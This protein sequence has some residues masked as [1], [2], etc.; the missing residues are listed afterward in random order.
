MDRDTGRGLGVIS[1]LRPRRFTERIKRD[2]DHA[3]DCMAG[4]AIGRGM[5]TYNSVTYV[6]GALCKITDYPAS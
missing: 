5:G 2:W 3:S 6:R 1:L 4:P